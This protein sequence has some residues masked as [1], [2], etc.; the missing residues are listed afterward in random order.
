MVSSAPLPHPTRYSSSAAAVVETRLRCD[1]TWVPQRGEGKRE[2]Q[3]GKQFRQRVRSAVVSV[4]RH[5]STERMPWN[6]PPGHRRHVQ[7]RGTKQNADRMTGR[8]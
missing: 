3:R 4:R 1:A 8:L 7:R 2:V 5:G 6:V